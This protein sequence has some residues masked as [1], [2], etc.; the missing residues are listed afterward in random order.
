MFRNDYE[1]VVNKVQRSWKKCGEEKEGTNRAR[2][3]QLI[4]KWK[5][6]FRRGEGQMKGRP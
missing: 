6:F 3:R 2:L 1:I 5:L 4:G